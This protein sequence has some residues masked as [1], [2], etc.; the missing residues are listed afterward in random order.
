M[1]FN[2]ITGVLGLSL[3]AIMAT[4]LINSQNAVSNQDRTVLSGLV[5]LARY[6]GASV[7]VTILTGLLP[8]VSQIS[9]AT[10]FLGTF[11]L[12]VGMYILGL[13]N[14]LT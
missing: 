2:I 13:L 10:Q 11:G 7:G 8:E 9:D 3:G 1:L 14:E 4:M 12:L 5:Q 6:L